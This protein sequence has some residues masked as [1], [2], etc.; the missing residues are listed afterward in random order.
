MTHLFGFITLLVSCL[1]VAAPVARAA[2]AALI[3]SSTARRALSCPEFDALFSSSA[4]LFMLEATTSELGLLENTAEENLGDRGEKDDATTGGDGEDARDAATSGCAAA[5]L[6][7]L[8]KKTELMT[9]TQ[10]CATRSVELR[11]ERVER[12]SDR[13]RKEKPVI[14]NRFFFVAEFFFF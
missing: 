4:S 8:L 5:P 1:C 11:K 2:D 14:K 6:R 12:S 10:T 7:F 3:P 9:E 13:E